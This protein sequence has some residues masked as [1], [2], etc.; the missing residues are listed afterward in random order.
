[1]IAILNLIADF[2]TYLPTSTQSPPTSK[3]NHKLAHSLRQLPNIFVNVPTHRQLPNTFAKFHTIIVNFQTCSQ[4]PRS[5]CHVRNI[6][7]NFHSHR[8]LPTSFANFHAVI[9][10]FQ[11]CLPTSTQSSSAS[12]HIW[13]PPK[14]FANFTQHHRLAKVCVNFKN[15]SS[16]DFQIKK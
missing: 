1:M 10:K 13:Q 6:N 14:W 4:I 16:V 9:A 2:Q 5:H 11:T 15:K 8:Q 3:Q 7:T 12:K